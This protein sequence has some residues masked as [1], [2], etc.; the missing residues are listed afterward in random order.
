M[1]LF[2]KPKKNIRQ[3]VAVHDSDE[4]NEA[5]N[6][7]TEKDTPKTEN[8]DSMDAMGLGDSKEN[9]MDIDMRKEKKKKK[10]HEE[11]AVISFIDE[12]EEGE[13]FQVKKSSQSRRLMKQMEKEKRMR[14]MQKKE[15][16]NGDTTEVKSEPMSPRASPAPDS[17][18]VRR[19]PPQP[20]I[21]SGRDAEMAGYHSSDDEKPSKTAGRGPPGQHAFTPRDSFDR[22]LKG[23]A[24]PDAAMIHAAR[25]RREQARRQHEAAPEFIPINS[26]GNSSAA[27]HSAQRED[28]DSGPEDDRVNFTVSTVARDREAR[29]DQFNAARDQEG[30]RASDEDD[31][32]LAQW[33]NQQ[34]KKAFSGAQMASV[35]AEHYLLPTGEDE[36]GAAAAAAARLSDPLGRRQRRPLAE[37]TPDAVRQ[38]LQQK[39]SELRLAQDG[40][41]TGRDRTLDDLVSGQSEIDR[42]ERAAPRAARR[43]Q[44]YQDIRGYV[45]DLIECFNEKMALIEELENRMLEVQRARAQKLIVRRRTDVRDQRMELDASTQRSGIHFSEQSAEEVASRRRRAAEREGRRTRRRRARELS[46]AGGAD[47]QD[48]LSSDDET[49]PADGEK[50]TK[51]G[52]A[53]ME[54]AE[55]VMEDVEDDFSTL[56]GVCR[57]FLEWRRIDPQA[58]RDAFV[59]LSLPKAL[60]P[61]VRLQMIGWNPLTEGE[62][63]E[64]ESRPWFAELVMFGVGSDPTAETED[65]IRDDPDC[66]LV[67]RVVER[68]VLTKITALVER[69]WDPLSSSQTLRLVHL[70]RQLARDYPTVTGGSGPLR[71]LLEAVVTAFTETVRQDASVPR[72]T[73]QQLESR[74]T[75]AAAFFYRQF[76]TCV[77]LLGNM[78]S[79]TELL[80]D[81]ALQKLALGTLL[82]EQMLLPLTQ[83]PDPVEAANRCRLVANTLP[84][85]WFQGDTTVPQLAM[86]V[87]YLSMLAVQLGKAANKAESLKSIAAVLKK[88]GATEAY[89]KISALVE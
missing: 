68:V 80:S 16:S 40:H 19:P 61:L 72:F 63:P 49:A 67:S 3:R 11:K 77:K 87:S 9:S 50:F 73:K 38:R 8:D 75:P 60:A 32:E 59:N 44:Y 7:A 74:S 24:I 34:I 4:E 29:R 27:G 69:V 85:S 36:V 88:V 39:L 78:M 45:T 41:V 17:A 35:T 48:G 55:A 62:C 71:R 81:G 20:P 31:R 43:Y 12:E 57:H 23:G 66:L 83:V 5:S 28:D 65:S 26:E 37:L 58:Y 10:K 51:D 42:L 86:F 84:R 15:V 82:N 76:T 18:A 25:K 47:H 79:W 6:D 53:I 22:V 54:A 2:K 64:L 52:E 70:V 56:A 13:V 21:L 1:S 14:E 33:E 30:G 89:Q 46:A